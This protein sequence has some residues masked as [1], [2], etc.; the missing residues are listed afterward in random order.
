MDV[1]KQRYHCT[2]KLQESSNDKKS[3]KKKTEYVLRAR[4]ALDS[5]IFSINIICINGIEINK[6]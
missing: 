6:W 5:A 3:L 4:R 1:L 2:N